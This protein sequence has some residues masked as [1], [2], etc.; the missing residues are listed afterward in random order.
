MRPKYI[1]IIL[2]IFS[3]ITSSCSFQSDEQEDVIHKDYNDI[4]K[5]AIEDNKVQEKVKYIENEES[6]IIIYVIDT[7]VDIF[8]VTKKINEYLE[9]NPDYFLNS[10][11]RYSIAIDNSTP[12]QSQYGVIIKNYETGV[13]DIQKKLYNIE[14]GEFLSIPVDIMKDHYIGD[15]TCLEVKQSDMENYYDQIFD[16]FPTINKVKSNIDEDVYEKIQNY[17]KDTGL[18]IEIE[19]GVFT[20]K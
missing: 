9:N 18:N 15:V 4:I 17:M 19:N 5:Y 3:I 12:N 1:F 20:K 8:S 16:F 11:Y 6:K 14:I 7:W 10:G 2:F 13:P